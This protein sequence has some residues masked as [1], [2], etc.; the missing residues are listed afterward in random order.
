M[1]FLFFGPPGS[2]KSVQGFA[3]SDKWQIPYISAGEIL[4]EAIA[5]RTALGIKAEQYIES[6]ELVPDYLIIGLLRE[7]LIKADANKGWILDG[8]P[9]N[10]SQ[11]EALD[12]LLNNL[13]QPYDQVVSFYVP[14]HILIERLLARGR[15]DDELEIINKRLDIYWE[16]TAPLIQEFQKR[17]CLT[18]VNG[19]RPVELITQFLVTAFESQPKNN[20]PLSHS[21][22][23]NS[24]S[25]IP[26]SKLAP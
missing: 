5:R 6:G 3:L 11:F 13:K 14:F 8:C 16:H 24:Q 7:R 4:H 15:F 17:R 26:N 10:Q 18:V 2:G 19:E 23:S 12:N 22:R 21:L 9:C 20:R 1:R 25:P